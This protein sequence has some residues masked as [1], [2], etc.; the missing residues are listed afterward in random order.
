MTPDNGTTLLHRQDADL[1]LSG[2][3]L[4]YKTR[5][6]PSLIDVTLRIPHGCTTALVGP[7]GS[8]KSTVASLLLRFIQP[9]TGLISIGGYPLDNIPPLVWRQMVSWVP[10]RPH[11]FYGTIGENI[12]MARPDADNEE[13]KTAARAAFAHDFIR[14]FPG[15]YNTQIGERG[16]RLSGGQQQRIALARAFLKN[17]PLLILDEGTG[18]LDQDSE[19]QVASAIHRLRQQRTTLIIAHRLRLVQDADQIVFLDKGKIRLTG[20]HS[21]LMAQDH[22]YRKLFNVYN[23]SLLDGG[24]RE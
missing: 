24:F 23:P 14:S 3:T 21:K 10:Q 20:S 16:V 11:L 22:R 6:E 8:G 5:E 15:G 17:A 19:T 4:L 9:T 2:V 1:L 7:S 18:Q 13:V 12:Q